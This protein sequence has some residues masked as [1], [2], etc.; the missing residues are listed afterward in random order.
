MVQMKA[1][2][3][4]YDPNGGRFS[5]TRSSADALKPVA[6]YLATMDNASSSNTHPMWDA[7]YA[8]QES[9]RRVWD[10]YSPPSMGYNNIAAPGNA[11]VEYPT[12]GFL[13]NSSEDLARANILKYYDRWS[14]RGGQ[15]LSGIMV[16]GAKIIFA[17]SVSHGR[18]TYAERARVGGAVD[19]AR[20]PKETFYAMQAAQSEAPTVNIMGHWTYPAGTTKNVYVMANTQQVQ[21]LTYTASGTLIH[22]YG[23]GTQ[24]NQFEFG[25]ANVQ[26]QAGKIKAIGFNNGMQ[27]A[28]QEIVSAGAPARIKLTPILGPQGF[29]ADG[30][31]VAM[32]DVEVTDA[33]G[34]RCP[35]DE[36]RIDF[37][38][39]GQ[40]KWLGGYNSGI[41]NSIFQNYLNTEARINR[42]FVRSTRTAGRFTLTATRSGLTSATAT[43]NSSAFTV[44]NGLT[45]TMPQGYSVTLGTEPS[46]GVPPTITP[47]GPSPTPTTVPVSNDVM[48][49]F[50]YTGTDGSAISPPMP[51]A[52]VVH[53]AQAG[54][55][56]YVDN[57]ATFPTLPSYLAGGDYIQAFQRD[58]AD[59]TSTDLYQFIMNRYG[60]IYQLIDSANAM[61][62]HDN[63]ASYGWTLL[64]ETVTINGRSHKIYKSRLMA[65]DE[66][67]YFASNGYGITLA[68]GSNLY[69]VFAV[70]AEQELQAPSQPVTVSSFQAGNLAAYAID[71]NTTTRWGAADGTFP[72]WLKI[73]LGQKD[74]IGSYQLNWYNNAARSYKYKIELSDDD[75]TYNLS[76]DKQANTQMGISNDRIVSPNTRAGRYVRIT[77]TGSSAGWAS[78]FEI[79]AMGVPGA[80]SITPTVTPTRTN[81]PTGPTLTPPRTNTPIRPRPP[82]TP[83]TNPA[84]PTRPPPRPNTPAA[85]NNLA[86]NHP[87]PRS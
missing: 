78:L 87:S 3:D 25:F 57:A 14:R 12:S 74:T 66:F 7:E 49:N 31:D 53:G 69:V 8:R 17:D 21:L 20:L 16:G 29:I 81:T 24:A 13:Y 18:M 42:V 38:Y 67:G 65:P 70:S 37:T 46:A 76:V 9:P 72:Q 11:I 23:F 45:L 75:V 32:F 35:T 43:I 54:M 41:Q 62:T 34:I 51:L 44:T 19:G 79:K 47:V 33:N 63:N 30:S 5:G 52:H 4:Q 84:P 10:K 28:T 64:P 48:T 1:V 2:N 39:S 86:H 15:G 22:D 55:Q 58:A 56:V 80:G 82:P 61:P 85:A 36:A 83:P 60:Y 71:G 77:V 50:A 6:E 73:D 27:V 40:A 59:T 26:W 68:P